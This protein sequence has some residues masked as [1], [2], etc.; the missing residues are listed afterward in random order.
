MRD[1]AEV[2]D[3]VVRERRSVRIYNETIPFDGS[4]VER[5]LSRAVLAPNSSN[6]QLWEFY[7]VSTAALRNELAGYCLGQK[8]ALTA[9]ELIVVVTRKDKWKER[10][11]YVLNRAKENF[12]GSEPDKEKMIEKYYGATIPVLFNN[13]ALGV[14]SLMKKTVVSWRGMFKPTPRE[15]TGDDVR[16]I[17]HKSAA[18][19]AQTFMLSVRAEG[20]DSCPMEGFDSVKVR[21]MLKL[22]SKA[23]INMI[24]SVGTA[25]PEGVYGPRIR[26]DEEEVIFH[27]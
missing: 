25:L 22:P 15:V 8:A 3:R 7:R 6:L 9:N 13:D 18:L 11:Q 21:K 20:Y 16:V 1:E 4:A 27:L 5:S 12:D 24:I 23:E 2:F 14:S 17:V 10:S 19:A 26:V